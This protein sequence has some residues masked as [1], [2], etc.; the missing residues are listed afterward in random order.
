MRVRRS[1]AI[2]MGSKSV[3]SRLATL[4]PAGV[5]ALITSGAALATG[6]REWQL[7]L[8]EPVTP[9]AEKIASFH[10]FLLVVITAISVFVLLLL[11]YTC[12]RFRESRNSSPSTTSHNT[13]IEV[14]WTVV[15]IMILIAIAIPSFRLIYFAD[16][17]A[18][19]DMTL[20]IVGNQWYW[21]Y[22]YPDQ[23]N[24]TF[25]A[26]MVSDEDIKPGQLRLLDTDNPVVLPVGRKVRLL[27]TSQDVIHAWAIAGIRRQVWTTV[28][29]RTQRDLGCRSISR[30]PITASAR[31]CAAMD[32]PSC[33][34]WVKAVSPADFDAWLKK[35]QKEFARVDE[36]PAVEPEKPVKLANRAAKK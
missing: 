5:V 34:S 28:P 33:R 21:T 15:P 3:T 18:D 35:A 1:L 31:S 8:P 30:A 7:G 13:I 12:W 4:F 29:G 22:E 16:R 11:L 32:T 27:L 23:G 6:P 17:V 36:A 25:D 26:N 14:I 9:T 19:A 10:D 24:F 20:K 2:E